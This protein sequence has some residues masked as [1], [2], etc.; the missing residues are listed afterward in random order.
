MDI[1]PQGEAAGELAGL[2]AQVPSPQ[3]NPQA[4][5][6]SANEDGKGSGSLCCRG[7][8]HTGVTGAG[9]TH[10]G[11]SPNHGRSQQQSPQTPKK[12]TK[13]K[14]MPLKRISMTGDELTVGV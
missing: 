9:R 13:W 14:S 8:A 12:K 10:G 11:S 2:D 1:E 5:K 4:V 3:A 7:W 6:Q